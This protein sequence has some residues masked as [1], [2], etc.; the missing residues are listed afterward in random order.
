M[1]LAR[2]ITLKKWE[3][4]IQSNL[5]NTAADAITADLRTG[6]NKLSLWQCREIDKHSQDIIDTVLAIGSAADQI[7]KMDIVLLAEEE[8]RNDSQ[9]IEYSLDET[10]VIDLSIQ[11][12]DLCEMNY[13]LLGRLAY[14]IRNAI[15]NDRCFRFSKGEVVD[16]I[17]N[18]TQNERLD[19]ARLSDRIKRTA[20]G[21]N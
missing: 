10:P 3:S 7:N 20:I 11:H 5:L 9:V 17:R 19:V 2:K 6:D 8:L 13:R 16:I 1:F 18:A 15:I 12:A 4:S 14:R 21:A